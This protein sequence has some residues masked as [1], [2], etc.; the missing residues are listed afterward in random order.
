MRLSSTLFLKFVLLVI[1]VAELA[2]LTIGLPM[3]IGSELSGDFDY[4]VVLIGLYFPAIP[5]LGGLYLAYKLLNY[6]EKNQVFSD[7]AVLALKQIKLS[8]FVI[9]GIFL[10]GSPYFYYLAEKDDAPG[11]LAMVLIVIF[12]S[13]CVATAAAVFQ[14]LLQKAVEIKSENDL[15]V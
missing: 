10:A 13:A 4:G 9:S 15:T 11:L 12:A 14:S 1:G 6:I 2:F 7:K 3:L 5:F 8:A